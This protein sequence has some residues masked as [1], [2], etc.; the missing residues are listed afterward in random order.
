[1]Q[2][3][4][5]TP[6]PFTEDIN[7]LRTS[8]DHIENYRRSGIIPDY[9]YLFNLIGALSEKGATQNPEID[10]MLTGYG[11]ISHIREAILKSVAE[12]HKSSASSAVLRD[13]QVF[14]AFGYDQHSQ[15][16]ER[17]DHLEK[18]HKQLQEDARRAEAERRRREQ[19][20]ADAR[21]REEERRRQQAEADRIRREQEAADRRREEAARAEAE[22]IRRERE[23]AEARRREQERRQAE[24]D[25][26]AEE[27]RKR[28]EDAAKKNAGTSTGNAQG[29]T[30]APKNGNSRTDPA[31][32]AKRKRHEEK[33]RQEKEE[34]RRLWD[35]AQTYLGN[36]WR[37]VAFGIPQDPDVR[38]TVALGLVQKF[39]RSESFRSEYNENTVAIRAGLEVLLP[40]V[41]AQLRTAGDSISNS[42]LKIIISTLDKLNSQPSSQTY[43][44]KTIS[45][46]GQTLYVSE[47][48]R[49]LPV[50]TLRQMDEARKIYRKYSNAW[51][52]DHHFNHGDPKLK[53]VFNELIKK[54]NSSFEPF[55]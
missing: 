52:P 28:K 37:S 34:N 27:E 45:K 7:R 41:W 55:K 2:T 25:R 33:D 9:N 18:H 8:C 26:K 40:E 50:L 46:F 22:R 12:N 53:V 42:D 31:A 4:T 36:Q 6:N 35:K 32:E 43:G 48:S 23:A 54:V 38:L 30:E 44:G 3:E 14:R 1:M 24:A 51:R 10:K 5:G 13:I 16:K 11:R 49:G 21:R 20:V 15:T 47:T 29:N 39:I 19:A 17:I